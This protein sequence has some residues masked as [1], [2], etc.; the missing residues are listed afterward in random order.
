MKITFLEPAMCCSTGL[1][2]EDV[3]DVLV[4]TAANVQWLKSLGHEV[5]RHN[6]SNDSNAF[7]QYPQAISKLQQEGLSALPFILINGRLVMSGVYPVKSQWEKWLSNEEAFAPAENP[8]KNS[9]GCSGS[10]CC[11]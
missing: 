8:A 10:G 1:C 2:G 5:N 4:A 11:S 3:D 9:G 6:I 7:M